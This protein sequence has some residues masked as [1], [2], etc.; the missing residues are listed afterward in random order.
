[1]N[2]RKLG[3]AML[4]ATASLMALAL[5]LGTIGYLIYLIFTYFSVPVILIGGA[6]ILLLSWLTTG[7][8]GD[9]NFMKGKV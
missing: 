3:F 9:A 7:F 8:Y 1:M 6:V 4:A 5:V 2:W